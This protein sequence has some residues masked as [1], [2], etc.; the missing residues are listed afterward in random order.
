MLSIKKQGMYPI[1]LILVYWRESVVLYLATN[2]RMHII[3]AIRKKPTQTIEKKKK[4][5]KPQEKKT[6]FR[7]KN[8]LGNARRKC[9]HAITKGNVFY[10]PWCLLRVLPV[11]EMVSPSICG[12]GWLHEV[13]FWFLYGKCPCTVWRLCD[14]CVLV[15]LFPFTSIS[16]L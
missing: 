5:W 15:L 8:V 11:L 4:W 14:M 2:T 9:L 13:K 1:Y 16:T 7:R 6:T 12:Q 3:A 10:M